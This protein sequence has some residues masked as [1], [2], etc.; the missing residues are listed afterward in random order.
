LTDVSEEL[1]ASII[2]IILT[3]MMEHKNPFSF[4]G[5]VTLQRPKTM[6]VVCEHTY[7]PQQN[8]YVHKTLKQFFLSV[9]S[10]YVM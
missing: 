7:K 3:L 2:R 6:T 9:Q 10:K 4:R 8:K 5:V 1:T